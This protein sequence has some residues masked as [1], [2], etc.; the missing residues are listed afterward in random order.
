M[1]PMRMVIAFVGITTSAAAEDVSGGLSVDQYWIGMQTATNQ[2]VPRRTLLLN[3]GGIGQI[4]PP[5]D[6]LNSD[7]EGTVAD[8]NGSVDQSILNAVNLLIASEAV[9]TS[10]DQTMLGDQIARNVV[11]G[12]TPDTLT[13]TN[14]IGENIANIVIADQVD[15]VRQS[16]GPGANQIVENLVSNPSASLNG[17]VQTGRNT[18]NV[19]LANVSIGSGEQLFPSDTVQRVDNLTHLDY[20]T[21]LPNGIEQHGTNIGNVLMADDVRNVARVFNGSQIVR[22]T[23]TTQNG[24]TPD[25]VNQSGLNIAN[26]VSA[27]RVEGLMQVSNGNQTVKNHLQGATLADMSSALSEY[28]HSSTNIVNL[29]DI[30]NTDRPQSDTTV[31]AAQTANQTQ[32]VQT[33]LGTHSQVGN[34]A[35]INR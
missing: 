26:F 29:L 15:A 14:Q 4:L 8:G 31:R 13:N 7:H 17:I 32:T 9:I 24:H 11:S 30:Q 21:A 35:T 2:I 19:V 28:T 34:A 5:H 12:L 16:F 1:Q 25:R 23:V 20:G 10:V 22:N 6:A 18:A 3:G 27:K 33:R